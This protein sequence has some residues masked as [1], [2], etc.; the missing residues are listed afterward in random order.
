MNQRRQ[1]D[2]LL[3]LLIALAIILVLAFQVF[4]PFLLTFTVA[5]SVALLLG[6]LHS[7]LTGGL[8]GQGTVAAG[9]IVLLTT[10]VILLP[11]AISLHLLARQ[12][13]VLAE[14]VRPYIQPA[15]LQHLLQ[16]IIAERLPVLRDLLGPDE[17]R[18]APLV[19]RVLGQLAGF[20][21]ALVQGALTGFT[22]IVFELL[23][24]LL[25]LFFLLKDGSRL[26]NELRPISPFSEE[27]EHLIFD[28]LGKTVKGALQ[29]IVVV[30]LVQGVMAT[31]GFLIFGVPSPFVWG[32]AVILA[33]MVPL[34]GSPLGWVPACVYLFVTAETWQAV[35]MLVYGTVVISGIDNVVKP[36]LLRGAAQIHPLLGFLSILGGVLAYGLS[37]F[38]V[39]PVVLSLVLSAI[40]IYRIDVLRI[41]RLRAAMSAALAAPAMAAPAGVAPEPGPP[42]PVV[43]ETASLSRE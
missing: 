32:S 39:G 21:N 2:V 16:R 11:V 30:P 41:E 37:G 5:A 43:S 8:R 40:R 25:M 38:L 35:G 17:A 28:H 10:L 20:A 34:L 23:L 15:E 31:V 3:P 27:Q 22:H 36:L 4:R 9:I 19:S 1:R 7:R 6:P 13:I 18:L 42:E 24:F 14:W 26:R 29:S 12:A 33:A